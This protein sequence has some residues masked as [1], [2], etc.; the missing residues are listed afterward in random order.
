MSIVELKIAMIGFRHRYFRPMHSGAA[1]P[2]GRGN[3]T[4]RV[5]STLVFFEV[6][7]LTTWFISCPSGVISTPNEFIMWLRLSLLSYKSQL[8]CK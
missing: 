6:A 3:C 8:N 2:K 4:Q 5:G 1:D 7:Q